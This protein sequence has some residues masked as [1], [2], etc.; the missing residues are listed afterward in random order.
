MISVTVKD[1]DEKTRK[2]LQ[3]CLKPINEATLEKYGKKGVEILR[4]VT[5][6][7]TGK[8]AESWS[9]SIEKDSKGYTL[10]WK[11]SNRNDGVPIALILQY[12]HGTRGGTYV[13]GIDYINPA[14]KP[15]F[16]EMSEELWREV[17]Q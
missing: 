15:L 6:K 17:T 11:N 4:Q 13:Q 16:N 7:D 9:Y 3:K 2:F 1:S 10:I 5:P 8:T 12:G 14:L